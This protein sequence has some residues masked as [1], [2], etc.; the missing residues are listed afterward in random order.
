MSKKEINFDD[1]R[2]AVVRVSN[3]NKQFTDTDTGEVGF[4]VDK[5]GLQS[6]YFEPLAGNFPSSCI[7]NSGTFA[8]NGGFEN[9]K[10][11]MVAVRETAP[12]EEGRRQF[13][14]SNWGEIE[15]ANVLELPKMVGEAV[16]LYGKPN[17][18][19]TLGEDETPSEETLEP[20]IERKKG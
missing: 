2:F 5:N 9:G 14:L 20:L 16:A 12:D 3:F 18:V 10:I 6:R 4:R 15:T 7:V 8:E 19:A 17:I 1:N 13:I 11:Y